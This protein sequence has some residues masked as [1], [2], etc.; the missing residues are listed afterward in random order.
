[1]HQLATWLL[2]FLAWQKG[3]TGVPCC[4]RHLV[5][6]WPSVWWL[7]PSTAPSTSGELAALL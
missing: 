6:S 2:C 4:T 5:C 1:M 7:Q 3:A